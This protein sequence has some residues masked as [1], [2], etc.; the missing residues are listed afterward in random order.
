MNTGIQDVYNLAWKL[1]FVI[2]GRAQVQVLETYNQERI[3]NAKQ[4]LA[5]TDRM[6][7]FVAGSNWLL[8]LIRTTIFPPAAL[9]RILNRFAK[10]SFR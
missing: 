1:A 4:L 8:T 6:F 9:L 2:K 3:A 10:G 5:T 7:E